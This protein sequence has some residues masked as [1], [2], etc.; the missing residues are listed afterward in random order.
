MSL[1]HHSVVF[2]PYNTAECMLSVFSLMV[3]IY[4]SDF[5]S[6][7]ILEDVKGLYQFI[8]KVP[9]GGP[10]AHRCTMCGKEGNDRGN[11]RKHVENIHFPGTFIYTCRMCGEACFSRNNLNHH[12]SKNHATVKNATNL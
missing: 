8:E 3:E 11:L 10:K 9:E 2:L 7:F 1:W 12:M 6:D 4:G 5:F